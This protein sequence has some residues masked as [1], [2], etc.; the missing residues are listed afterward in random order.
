MYG[1]LL[2]RWLFEATRINGL[3]PATLGLETKAPLHCQG[4][5]LYDGHEQIDPMKE[6]RAEDLQIQNKTKSLRTIYA[7]KGQRWDTELRQI[8]K[9][10]DLMVELEL[11]DDDVAQTDSASASF[12]KRQD[13]MQDV[14]DDVADD[15]NQSV[16]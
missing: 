13:E 2:E 4:E 15:L 8:A 11:D 10:K 3:L 9:E 16:A 6:A 12:F 5:W 7:E 14:A 1:K